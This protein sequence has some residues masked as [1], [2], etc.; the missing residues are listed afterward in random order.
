MVVNEWF[1]GEF[2]YSNIPLNIQ[3]FKF[4]VKYSNYQL[5]IQ[6]F[7]EVFIASPRALLCFWTLTHTSITVR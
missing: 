5:N 4:S 2:I 1:R 3:I 7:R 6:I